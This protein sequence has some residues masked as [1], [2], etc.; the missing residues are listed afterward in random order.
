MGRQFEFLIVIVSPTLATWSYFDGVQITTKPRRIRNFVCAVLGGQELIPARFFF[1]W[2]EHR[3][4]WNRIETRATGL[5]IVHRKFEARTVKRF[6]VIKGRERFVR[7]Q[8]VCCRRPRSI[9]V[10]RS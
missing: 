1:H 10:W 6:T 7:C 4:R 9:V 5:R 3:V 2:W 8:T